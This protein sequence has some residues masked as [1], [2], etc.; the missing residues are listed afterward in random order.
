[1]FV[2]ELASNLQSLIYSTYFGGG[3]DQWSYSLALTSSG[4]P[5]FGGL[6]DATAAQ[7][8]ATPTSSNAIQSQLQGTQNVFVAALSIPPN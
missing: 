3:P 2:T 8:G 6:S 5:V 7:G 1:M 4:S